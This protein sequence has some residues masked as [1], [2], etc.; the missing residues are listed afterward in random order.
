[1]KLL[2]YKIAW[3]DDQPAQAQGYRD[4]IATLLGRHGFELTIDWIS[5]T[6]MLDAFL[7]RLNGNDNYDMIMVDWK[8]GQMVSEASGGASVAHKIRVG[9]SFA[10]IVFY[11]A[12][13]PGTLRAEIAKQLIDGVFCVNRIHFFEEAGPLVKASVKRF[14][15]FNAMRGLFLAAVAEFDEI[16]RGATFKA[17]SDLPEEYQQRVVNM[18]LD[19]RISY[20]TQQANIANEH[21]RPSDLAS[22]LKAI[23]PSSWELYQCLLT[24]LSFATPSPTFSNAVNKFMKYGD[25]VLIPRNDMAHLK[26]KEKNG[27]KILVRGDREWDAAKFDGLRHALGDHHDN[28]Q[29]I[30]KQL[31]DD[32]VA[33]LKK[34]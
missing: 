15:D 2:E 27:E 4:R 31:V 25:E 1:M 9:N 30:K 10:T 34:T 32:L 21:A 17:Y 5:S 18:L 13:A 7:A 29:Y 24:I 26:E 8:L 20:A 22:V 19:G 14:T 12:A 3:I 23:Q 16:I 28:L 33:A 11:S 6:D